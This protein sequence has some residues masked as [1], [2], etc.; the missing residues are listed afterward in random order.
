M[1]YLKL[2]LIVCACVVILTQAAPL[3][4]AQG[5]RILYYGSN[6]TVHN[7][8]TL[9]VQE[10]IKVTCK[11]I[12]INH[13]IYR[14]FPTKYTDKYGN[15]VVVGFKV[16]D[17]QKN[18][19][20][21]PYQLESLSNGIRI[22]IGSEDTILEPGNYTYT[23]F[24]NVTR[25]L[26]FF[27]DHDELYW[28]VTGNGWKF[29]ID[30]VKAIVTLP[31]GVPSKDI[32]L[33]AYTGLKGEKGNQYKLQVIKG[34]SVFQTTSVLP[35][36][37]GLTIVVSFPNGYVTA[38]TEKQKF[39][40]FLEDNSG[41]LHGLVELI[42]VLAYFIGAWLKL[43]RDPKK[44]T[45]IPAWDLPNG[46]SPAALRYIV[47]KSCDD[48]SI[49][50][51]II[52]MAVKGFLTIQEENGE[53]NLSKARKEHENLSQEERILAEQLLR[54]EHAIKISSEYDS[55]VQTA[56]NEFSQYLKTSF[57]T[58]LFST[59]RGYF[60]LGAGVSVAAL[61]LSYLAGIKSGQFTPDGSFFLFWLSIWTFGVVALIK[62]VIKAW[63][64]RLRV[65]KVASAVGLTLFAVPF[66]AAE[67]AVIYLFGRSNSGFLVVV[68]A[69]ALVN[70]LFYSLLEAYTKKGRSL[71]D[72][73]EGFKQYLTVAEKDRLQALNPPD[74]TPELYERFLPYAIA[75]DVEDEWTRQFTDVLAN[76]AANEGNYRSSWYISSLPLTVGMAGFGSSLSSS[77]SSAV[78]SSSS[79]PGSSS[80]S[81][82]GG[83]SGGG[84]GGGGGG[85][86]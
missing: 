14:D 5:E 56:V 19:L 62:G 64:G 24:Y 13:G 80:G 21:E 57:G 18:G 67:V 43:G 52:N 38:P 76:A 75:L 1:K 72:K 46:L 23:I 71:L 48:K 22:R 66:I 60:A 25:E 9:T 11:N 86:W 53:Y 17:V 8:S 36:W 69:F 59:N 35:E 7:D 42:I 37:S 55:R 84:G 20:E 73:I 68:A 51:A 40:W 78:S 2:I 26:G 41:T 10:T 70:I 31:P 4:N 63:R 61:V 47:K 6:I 45:I 50:V 12:N 79:S 16:M 85:G 32:K 3:A 33:D 81:G 49:A 28:N 39:Q 77:I 34:K 82:G 65:A 54:H 15:N 58:G 29:P 74:K 27:K 30:K 83:S 44:G